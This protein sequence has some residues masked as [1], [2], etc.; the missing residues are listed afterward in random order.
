MRIIMPKWLTKMKLTIVAMLVLLSIAFAWGYQ[1][2]QM[3]NQATYDISLGSPIGYFN[4]L[5]QGHFLDEQD[6][7]VASIMS[8]ST[9]GEDLGQGSQASSWQ[10]YPIPTQ[11]YMLWFS[12]SDNQFY[13][14][15]FNLPPK[16]ELAYAFN[17]QK[18]LDVFGSRA[19]KMDKAYNQ[20]TVNIAPEGKVYLYL[21][22]RMNKL[23]GSYQAT[24]ID[25]D[26]LEWNTQSPF[27]YTKDVYR[28][29]D[30]LVDLPDPL[31]PTNNRILVTTGPKI[32][33]TRE[34]AIAERLDDFKML[35][36]DQPN[37]YN[38]GYFD[39]VQISLR[40][41]GENVEKLVAYSVSTIN[42]ERFDI[43]DNSEENIITSIPTILLVDFEYKGVLKR[44]QFSL[45]S[46]F[47]PS[48]SKSELYQF[49]QKNFNLKQ[50]VEMILN[51][52]N[53]DEGFV[54]FQQG[55]KRVEFTNISL[56]ERW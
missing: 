27:E 44:Y 21:S 20:L 29:A 12:L 1:E 28:E 26:W 41:E 14:G 51:I 50:K 15:T 49:Y 32:Y 23:I 34:E 52:P 11:L 10:T 5:G 24:P 38:E 31:D 33:L 6:N 36:P 55:E 3:Q 42:G 19:G 2:H 25:Y 47:V 39:P 18:I 9:G 53:E 40:L 54:Y 56:D 43:L 46:S 37:S 4:D 30:P 48:A 22:G 16:Q 8:D 13:E 35:V 17:E 7:V 45:S